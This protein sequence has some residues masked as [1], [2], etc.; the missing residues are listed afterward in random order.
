MAREHVILLNQE[1]PAVKIT[2]A[3]PTIAK[4][5]SVGVHSVETAPST[6]VK[7]AM[8]RTMKTP[9]AAQTSAEP[10]AVVTVMYSR[11]KKNAIRETLTLTSWL[12]PAGLTAGV[13]DVE[14]E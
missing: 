14:M 3:Q 12:T 8:T 13:L 6:R 11:K 7:S 9:T 5:A 4:E 2:S 1:V 10:P